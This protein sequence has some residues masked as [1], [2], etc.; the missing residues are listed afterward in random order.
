MTPTHREHQLSDT[1]LVIRSNLPGQ[2]D[3][4]VVYFGFDNWAKASGF[5]FSTQAMLAKQHGP[6]DYCELRKS[7]RLKHSKFEVKVRKLTKPE[8]LRLKG[9]AERVHW[10]NFRPATGPGLVYVVINETIVGT[11]TKDSQEWVLEQLS[12]AHN[13]KHRDIVKLATGLIL[14]IGVGARLHQ[15]QKAS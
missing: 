14:G 9:D 6:G 4:R 2:E 15:N 12:K 11:V 3:W 5:I 8:V 10:F 13:Y 7:K 1:C